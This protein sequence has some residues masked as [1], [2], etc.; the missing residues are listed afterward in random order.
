MYWFPMNFFAHK[1]EDG[2][3]HYTHYENHFYQPKK[4]YHF[5]G[6]IYVIQGGITFSAS[7]MFIS[8]MKGQKNVTIT[9]EE[10]GG[11]FYGN[12][13]MHLPFI[14]L[15]NSHLRIGLPMYR[16]VIDSTREKNGR[17][18]VPDVW[19]QPSSA[20]IKKGTDIKLQTIRQM[21]LEKKKALGT[22]NGL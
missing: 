14:E 22:S 3:F 8:N 5:G 16:L 15:P 2:R 1:K 13:A 4:N 7:T 19:I 9:G 12:T 6:N 18:I 10:T 11:G 20:A 17:G 21:I